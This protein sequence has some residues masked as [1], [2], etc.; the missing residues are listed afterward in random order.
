MAIE[1]KISN[2][3]T[4]EAY[5]ELVQ[6][7]RD[8]LPNVS[9]TSDF[10]SGYCGETEED[11]KETLSLMK[12]VKYDM[13]YMFAY[14]M[15]EKTHAHRTQVDDVPNEVKKRR[16]NEVIDT[17]RETVKEKSLS[18]KG[19]EQLV[20]IE[21]N[22]NKRE[23]YLFGRSDCN[24]KVSIPDVPVLDRRSGQ[25]SKIKAG[26]YVAVRKK[27]EKKKKTRRFNHRR[28]EKIIR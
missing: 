5:L 18:L 20:L 26:D 27:E 1:F 8:I 12:I 11:H 3:Y 23:E 15:R 10:I 22:S 28:S 13:A 17:Y 16:L 24:K 14:S 2:S 6:K 21:G 9:L 19:T 25:M 7:I 4:R